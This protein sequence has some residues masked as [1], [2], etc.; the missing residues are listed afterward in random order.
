MR[1]FAPDSDYLG[2]FGKNSHF[3][4]ESWGTTTHFPSGQTLNVELFDVR[5]IFLLRRRSL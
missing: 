1:P 2:Y 5:T 3:T 4:F